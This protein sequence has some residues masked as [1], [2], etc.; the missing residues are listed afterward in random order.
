MIASP[1]QFFASVNEQ[2]QA[3]TSELPVETSA[4][5]SE[6]N[7]INFNIPVTSATPTVTVT[8]TGSPTNF[9]L[10]GLPSRPTATATCRPW[11]WLQCVLEGQINEP[12]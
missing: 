2:N 12:S 4:V 11:T 7:A 9:L 5:T 3:T 10:N 1:R 8:E 6:G